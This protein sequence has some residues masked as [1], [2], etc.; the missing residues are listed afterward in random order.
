M[1]I[2]TSFL[3]KLVKEDFD[4]KDQTL[5]GKIGFILN[6]VILQITNVLNK[7]LAIGNLSTQIKTLLVTVDATGKPSNNL[8]FEST[9]NGKCILITVGRAQNLTNATTYPTSAPFIT[10]SENNGQIAIANIT[11]LT[12][13]DTWQLTIVAYD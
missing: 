4:A 5:V 9:L 7:G 3:K 1:S 8:S 11:G 12:A 13:N 6:P 10:F 2:T